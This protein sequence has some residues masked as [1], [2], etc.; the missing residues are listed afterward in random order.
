MNYSDAFANSDL[1][2]LLAFHVTQ[3]FDLHLDLDLDYEDLDLDFNFE[4]FD[5]DL[6]FDD[7]DLTTSLGWEQ[8]VGGPKSRSGV[9]GKSPGGNLVANPP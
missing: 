3:D 6:D 7:D 4:D 8:E 5:F 2:T 1:S 9:K